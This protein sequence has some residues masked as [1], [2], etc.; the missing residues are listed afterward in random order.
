[1]VGATC[2]AVAHTSNDDTHSATTRATTAEPAMKPAPPFEVND[3]GVSVGELK[4][5][6]DTAFGAGVDDLLPDL[7]QERGRPLDAAGDHREILL[8]VQ[9]VCDGALENSG[10]DVELPQDLPALRVDGLQVA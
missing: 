10:P 4:D 7:S 6:E 8:A 9:D 3:D 2:C 1:M 5:H